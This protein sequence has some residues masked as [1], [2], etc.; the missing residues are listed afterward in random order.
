MDFLWRY[1][2]TGSITLTELKNR[3]KSV[4]ITDV[5]KIQGR[6][7]RNPFIPDNLALEVYTANHCMVI[8]VN[9]REVFK[10]IRTRFCN[11]TIGTAIRDNKYLLAI[12]PCNPRI[13]K[14]ITYDAVGRY[15]FSLDVLINL[16]LFFVLGASV[17]YSFGLINVW[18][19]TG[20]LFTPYLF[21]IPSYIAKIQVT[22]DENGIMMKDAEETRFLPFNEIAL[23]EKRLHHIRVTTK[24]GEL[25]YF[26]R[27]CYMLAELIKEFSKEEQ[28]RAIDTQQLDG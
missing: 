26:P 23:V 7:W 2:L 15:A 8:T 22:L 16:L 1:K 25:V 17:V 4:A 24:S 9:E 3:R 5:T 19:L 13:P 20:L 28:Q 10:L 21:F 11:W 12:R 6:F 27:A 18:L 14:L